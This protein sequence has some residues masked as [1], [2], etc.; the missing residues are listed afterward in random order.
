MMIDDQDRCQWVKFLLVQA[1]PSGS[2]K[3]VKWLCVHVCVCACMSA[4][5]CVCVT[6]QFWT[7]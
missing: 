6:I 4:Y 2:P 3:A 7:G 5:V 1:H